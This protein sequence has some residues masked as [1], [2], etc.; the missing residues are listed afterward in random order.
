MITI[1]PPIA[2]ACSISGTVRVI[3]PAASTCRSAPAPWLAVHQHLVRAAPGLLELDRAVDLVRAHL[4]RQFLPE[5]AHLER[6]HL[7][8]PGGARQ[9]DRREPDRP[10]PVHRHDPARLEPL[11]PHE[12]PVVGD[13]R[14]LAQGS[15]LVP[16][17]GAA[18]GLHQRADRPAVLGA[19]HKLIGH[20]PRNREPD[21][22]QIQTLIRPA[23]P[24]RHTLPA[25]DHLLH[26]HRIARPADPAPPRRPRPP[27]R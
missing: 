4:L 27:R 6:H 14:R 8:R 15:R 20:R 10:G 25:P 11:R 2:I 16:G 5:R 17:L 24:A 26:G 12:H 21:L 13:A 19:H 23:V 22:L 18:V 9:R 7:A 1:F 3:A